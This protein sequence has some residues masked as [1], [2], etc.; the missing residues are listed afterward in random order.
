MW[1]S[2]APAGSVPALAFQTMERGLDGGDPSPAGA[3]G[4]QAEHWR[5]A[6][7]AGVRGTGSPALLLRGLLTCSGV[8]LASGVSSL[9]ERL[10]TEHVL[11]EAHCRDPTAHLARQPVPFLS[12]G[13]WG[14]FHG[15]TRTF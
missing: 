6:A 12:W 7:S 13:L 15:V 3:P 1:T 8:L 9:R 5:K 10:G 2:S 4:L 11:L 14:V